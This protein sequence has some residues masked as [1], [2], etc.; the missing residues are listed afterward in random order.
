MSNELGNFRPED[1]LYICQFL[2]IMKDLHEQ[3]QPF[4]GA[5]VDH[6]AFC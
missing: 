1:P 5:I 6:N 2:D 3:E 4:L